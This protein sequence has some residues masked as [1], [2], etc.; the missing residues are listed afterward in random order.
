MS[1]DQLRKRLKE[2]QESLRSG[3]TTEIPGM[4]NTYQPANPNPVDTYS[5]PESVMPTTRPKTIPISVP[6]VSAS[7]LV[8]P[9]V[10]TTNNNTAKV[11]PKTG[12]NGAKTFDDITTKKPQ[13]GEAGIGNTGLIDAYN[14]G[15]NGEDM[16][17]ETMD[18]ASAGGYLEQLEAMYNAGKQDAKPADGAAKTPSGDNSKVNIPSINTA[19]NNTQKGI[20]N[21]ANLGYTAS[22]TTFDAG[23]VDESEYTDTADYSAAPKSTSKNNNS[24]DLDA[25]DL[26]KIE[27]EL[28]YMMDMMFMNGAANSNDSSVQ[29]AYQYVSNSDNQGKEIPQEDLNAYYGFMGGVDNEQIAKSNQIAVGKDD[30]IGLVDEIY[31]NKPETPA[32]PETKPVSPVNPGAADAAKPNDDSEQDSGVT[33]LGQAG[34]NALGEIIKPDP[35]TFGSRSGLLYEAYNAG[36][37]GID[38]S[39]ELRDDAAAGDFLDEIEK[40]YQAGTTDAKIA[41]GDT[42]IISG[43]NIDVPNMGEPQYGQGDVE[44]NSGS[45]VNNEDSNSDE[46]SSERYIITPWEKDFDYIQDMMFLNGAAS[47]ADPSVQT[48]YQYFADLSNKGKAIPQ[49]IIDT[50]QSFIESVDPDQRTHSHGIVTGVPLKDDYTYQMGQI[51]T[52]NRYNNNDYGLEEYDVI[53]TGPYKGWT[54]SQG[55]DDQQ[56]DHKGHLGYDLGGK[57]NS[58]IY[59]ILPGEIVAM[60]WNKENPN[61]T[62]NGITIVI[63]HTTPDGRVFYS[64]YSHLARIEDDIYSGKIKT[65]GTDT[66][67]GT[68]GGTGKKNKGV[69]HLH[70]AVFTAETLEEITDPIGY[71]IKK[72]DDNDY[73]T[74]KDTSGCDY[75]YYYCKTTRDSSKTFYDPFVVMLTFGAIIDLFPIIR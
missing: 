38:L 71:T 52:R 19:E 70:L 63:K 18:N 22:N 5:A 20:D 56:T 42:V 10:K 44:Q 23:I 14:A 47:S 31:E 37:N 6:P 32:T 64:S 68:R 13:L 51:L 45:S 30:E 29:M 73:C 43:E 24:T 1:L 17:R 12:A 41:K 67:I 4:E 65:I 59:S 16:S 36:L 74:F 48:A 33:A 7:R 26:K 46:D 35:K 40:M 34:K 50:F 3:N 69:S 72:R 21:P 62:D 58:E 28:N 55:F 60:H 27:L 9:T 57:G 25:E 15:L 49:E 11:D 75:N 66:K 8:V 61:D 2:L 39:Q 54:V 53:S